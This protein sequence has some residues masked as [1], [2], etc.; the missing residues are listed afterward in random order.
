L[1]VRVVE[2]WRYPVKSLQGE[3]LDEVTV[4]ADG[5]DGDRR[6]AIFDLP[7]RLPL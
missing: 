6:Y 7:G 1:L 4:T 3:R 2:L 5:L